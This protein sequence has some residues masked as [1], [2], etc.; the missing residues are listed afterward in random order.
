[1]KLLLRHGQRSGGLMGNKS[2]FILD[3]RVEY[4]PEESQ[5]IRKYKLG[6]NIIYRSEANQKK[7]AEAEAKF[8]NGRVFSGLATA[9]MSRN[10]MHI[11]IDSIAKG[12]Q[13]EANDLDELLA[14][15]NQI[16]GVCENLKSYIET[17]K[18][19]DGREEVI[20]F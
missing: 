6:G 13:I 14:A 19:F 5:A 8:D 7:V 16:K 12:H 17:A 20:E 15:E 4:A 10:K 3:A 18:T 11:T 1:M 2:V 9:V